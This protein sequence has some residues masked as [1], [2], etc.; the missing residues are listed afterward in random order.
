MASLVIVLRLKTCIY[1]IGERYDANKT[2]K[3]NESYKYVETKPKKGKN[4]LYIVALSRQS[5]K[6]QKNQT[7]NG[8]QCIL[9]RNLNL[10]LTFAG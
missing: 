8:L 9:R 2:S 3:I 7:Y 1:V 10:S 4:M 5:C 6:K